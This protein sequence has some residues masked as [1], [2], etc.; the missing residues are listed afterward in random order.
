[1]S[2]INTVLGV[3]LGYAIYFAYIFT[4]SYGFAIII[5]AVI[6][7]IVLFPVSVLAH[8]NSIRLLQIQPA[9]HIIK[10]RYAGDKEQLNEEQYNLFKKEKYSPFVGLI[11]LFLQLFLI[12][13]VMQVMYHPLQH[14]LRLEPDAVSVISLTEIGRA[15]V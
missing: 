12:I 10:R 1:M 11:P 15:H 5:F 7:K 6:A 8:K 9:L 3:P 2:V 4:N 14:L 13:G